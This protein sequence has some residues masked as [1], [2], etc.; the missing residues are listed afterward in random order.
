MPIPIRTLRARADDLPNARPHLSARE[1]D[2]ED[3][4]LDTARALI[5]HFGRVNLTLDALAVAIRLA[6]ATIRRH[7]PDLDSLLA[8]LITRHLRAIAC[9]LWPQTPIP[10]LLSNGAK[11]A[12]S[13]PVRAGIKSFAVLSATSTR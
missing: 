5:F 4:I 11:S 3:R 8:E 12:F 10:S 9:A 1:L 7:V 2:R 13:T 6:P